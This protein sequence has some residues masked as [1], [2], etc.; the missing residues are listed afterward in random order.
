MVLQFGAGILELMLWRELFDGQEK[1]QVELSEPTCSIHVKCGL[2]VG[3]RTVSQAPR[4]WQPKFK[5]TRSVPEH[6]V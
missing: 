1:D 3:N 2:C 5:I 4:L 6:G